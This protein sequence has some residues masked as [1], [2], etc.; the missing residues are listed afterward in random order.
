[1]LRRTLLIAAAC[2]GERALAKQIVLPGTKIAFKPPE[3]FTELTTEEI[4]ARWMR[5]SPPEFVV[6]NA[7]RGTTIAYGVKDQTVSE[8]GLEALLGQFE[9]TFSRLIAGIV[10]KK[11]EI[12]VINGKRW[13]YLE[14]TSSALDTDIHNILLCAPY[15]RRLVMFNFNSTREEF[16]RVQAAL[17]RSIGSIALTE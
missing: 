10:W 1:M 15:G 4:R 13:I 3:S 14:M 11:K 12:A 5:A 17:R 9:H 7:T 2:L 6:G 8:E 16:P